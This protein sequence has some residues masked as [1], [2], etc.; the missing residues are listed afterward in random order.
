[1][2]LDLLLSFVQAPQKIMDHPVSDLEALVAEYPY[3]SAAQLLLL[4]QYKLQNSSKFNKQLRH[5]AGVL[6]D[7]KQ[8][9]RLIE[10]WPEELNQAVE[11]ESDITVVLTNDTPTAV[12]GAKLSALDEVAELAAPLSEVPWKQLEEAQ[13]P[14]IAAAHEERSGAEDSEEQLLALSSAPAEAI[15]EVEAAPAAQLETV[16]SIAE[17]VTPLSA[18]PAEEV[19]DL[20][21]EITE[22]AAPIQE[23]AP[24]FEDAGSETSEGSAPVE[25]WPVR[26]EDEVEEATADEVQ[27]VEAVAGGA[28][29]AEEPQLEEAIVAEKNV[30]S[31]EETEQ[32]IPLVDQPDET[33]IPVE[34]VISAHKVTEEVTQPAF[35]PTVKPESSRE[36]PAAAIPA[37]EK[38]VVA[39][40][41]AKPHDRLSWFK[42]FAGKPLREQSDEVLDQLYQEHMQQDFLRAPEQDQQI[43]AIR[44]Q[45]N[46]NEEV[47]SSK[48]LEE[49]IRRLAYESISDD[50]LP[51]S[52]TLAGIYAAQYDY[53]KAIRIYQK[54]ILKFPDKMSYFARL[55]EELRSKS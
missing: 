25:E 7:R 8:L 6:P 38:E 15:A 27:S 21:E 17:P 52:E 1:M 35:E 23:A 4:K 36:A 46:R 11:K 29:A 55:I 19:P 48:A 31:K 10:I 16:A 9:Y 50:E 26:P 42:F 18:T 22:E 53:K 30:L 3:F 5:A 40:F 33:E 28:S 54:L 37:S 20:V 12:E 14:G 32:I 34:K 41:I 44:A 43:S 39:E 13:T 24:A 47:P 45:I 51:A 2:N 49:E